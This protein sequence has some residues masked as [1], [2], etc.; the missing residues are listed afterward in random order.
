MPALLG[1]PLIG[2]G[3]LLPRTRP[4]LAIGIPATGTLADRELW[5]RIHRTAGYLVVA[6]GG[7][8]LLIA[9]RCRLRS[10]R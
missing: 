9:S 7:V 2:I 1:L 6:L 10:A 5:T 4:N 8:I 3:N